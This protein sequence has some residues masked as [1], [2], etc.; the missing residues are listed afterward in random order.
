MAGL[1]LTATQGGR[2][3]KA[4]SGPPVMVELFTS[5]GCSSCPPADALV[6][7][8]AERP[9]IIVV[10]WPV[11]YW[12][13]LGWKDTLSRHIF[14]KRQKAYMQ[15]FDERFVYTPQIV[16]NGRRE[17]VG[18]KEEK[19]LAAI[20]EAAQDRSFVP[21]TVERSGAEVV[22]KIGTG[23]VTEPATIWMVDIL[24]KKDVAIGGGENEG[25]KIT[26]T[27]IAR[28]IRKVGVWEGESR[29]I[30]LK[31]SEIA[32]RGNGCTILLQD[33]GTGPIRCALEIP[34]AVLP[35]GQ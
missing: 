28:D 26:Y 34:E 21:M 2:G 27:N 7:K 3:T 32:R 22:L 6:T 15:T 13:Y 24:S 33:D 1:G 11:D 10:S 25:R 4:E 19:V 12:N 18:S 14:T 35:T 8:Q 31:K 5:Q 17:M 30:S 16:V 29:N 23:E 20:E 9:G